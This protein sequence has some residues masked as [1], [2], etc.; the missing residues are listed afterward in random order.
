MAGLGF[1]LMTRRLGVRAA[2]AI[3]G[4]CLGGSAI[5]MVGIEGAL[6]AYLAA[7]LFGVGIGGL[8]TI[9][10][11]AWA[12]YFGRRSFGAIRGLALSVQVIATASGPPLSGARRDWTG[13]ST[14]A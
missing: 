14:H 9:L 12:D 11:I 6:H 7:A 13:H 4:V 10:P 8:L 1:G 2:L 3:V 5:A